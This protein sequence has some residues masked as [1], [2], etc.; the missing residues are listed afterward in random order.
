MMRS[1]LWGWLQVVY[2]IILAILL[3]HFT[4]QAGSNQDF[5]VYILTL[6][7]VYGLYDWMISRAHRAALQAFHNNPAAR[8]WLAE[9]LCGVCIADIKAIRSRFGLSLRDAVAVLDEYRQQKN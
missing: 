2:L 1:K 6:L 9:N 3:W 8:Q 5:L 4:R 7:L